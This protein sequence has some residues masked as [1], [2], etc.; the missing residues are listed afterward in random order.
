VYKFDHDIV[1]DA[2]ELAEN[3]VEVRLKLEYKAY[4]YQFQGVTIILSFLFLYLHVLL[5]AGH[6][7]VIATGGFWNSKA[8]SSMADLIVLGIGSR[9]SDLVE[10][11]GGGV[12]S[13]RTWAFTVSVRNVKKDQRLEF[14]L[15]DPARDEHR[16]KPGTA[17]PVTAEKYS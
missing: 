17:K 15:C 16:G 9:P 1:G 12:K 6:V 4:G 13:W 10:N 5:V 14:V 8:W 7:L 3:K 11:T 2:A